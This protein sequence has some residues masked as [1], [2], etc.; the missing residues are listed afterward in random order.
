MAGNAEAAPQ[1]EDRHVLST[2][3][4]EVS[5]ISARLFR[6]IP[7]LVERAARLVLS[8]VC[9][10][11]VAAKALRVSRWAVNRAVTA[12]QESRDVGVVGRPCALGPVARAELQLR[13]HASK[14]TAHPMTMAQIAEQVRCAC[15]PPLVDACWSMHLACNC[16]GRAAESSFSPTSG[17]GCGH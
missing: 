15:P 6:H 10:Q 14:D 17:L 3:P 4:K 9:S 2:D 16:A 12:I 11:R 7:N 13:I 5:R 1:Q 8:N